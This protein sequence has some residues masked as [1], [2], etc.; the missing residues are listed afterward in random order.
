[1]VKSGVY[2]FTKAEKTAINKPENGALRSGG[3]KGYEIEKMDFEVRRITPGGG[4]IKR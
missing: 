1:M 2:T 4:I 3:T